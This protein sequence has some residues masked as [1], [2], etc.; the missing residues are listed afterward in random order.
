MKL[1]KVVTRRQ[2]HH[3]L[4]FASTLPTIQRKAVCLLRISSVRSIVEIVAE[5]GPVVRVADV[6]ERLG[7]TRRSAR[8]SIK[9][10][11]SE[12]LAEDASVEGERGAR[13]I[14]LHPDTRIAWVLWFQEAKRDEDY[15]SLHKAPGWMLWFDTAFGLLFASWYS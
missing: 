15:D 12:T 5:E 13:K 11:T 9:M 1:G 6:A 3:V 10:L 7:I 4:H 2:G 8:R 14:T